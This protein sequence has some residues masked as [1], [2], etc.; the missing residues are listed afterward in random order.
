MKTKIVSSSELSA[1]KGLRAENY[2]D[3]PGWENIWGG[4]R[5]IVAACHQTA[6]EK[7]WWEKYITLKAETPKYYNQFLPDFLGSKLMLMVS[8][9]A[10]T[11]EEIREGRDPNEIYYSAT[12]EGKAVV[13]PRAVVKDV[14][15]IAGRQ[16]EP[17]PEGIAIELADTV[18]RIFDLAAYLGI[19]IAKAIRIKMD[20]NQGRSYRHGGKVL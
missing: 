10:E 3:G 5:L 7:G 14:M 12:V 15:T 16:G 13:G 2:M 8:E 17:K 20:Y 6:V 4:F 19:D 11:L 1:E 9:L 18:I